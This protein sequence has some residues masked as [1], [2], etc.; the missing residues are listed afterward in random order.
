MSDRYSKMIEELQKAGLTPAKAKN[1]LKA[2]SELGAK[3]PEKLKALLVERRLKTFQGLLL[4]T[5]LDV[6][7]C[8]GGFYIGKASS[9]SNIPGSI[10]FSLVGYFL[11]CYYFLQAV[12]QVTALASISVAAK[13]Y[14][15]DTD[16]LLAAVRE[17]AGPDQPKLFSSAALVVNTLKVIQTL[18]QIGEQLQD[19]GS[20]GSLKGSSLANLS[21][22]LT[23]QRAEEVY[24]FVPE[25]YGL[26]EAEAADIAGVFSRFDTNEDGQLEQ[27]ELR[28]LCAQLGTEISEAEAK[29]AVRILDETKSGYIQFADFVEWFQGRRPRKETKEAAAQAS[30]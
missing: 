12:F 26:T 1:V 13:R 5:V 30:Q 16:V 15:T 25:K 29:E 20:D 27:S 22:Y 14:S 28:N 11:A 9:E 7:A 23:L 8:G 18:E 2:W 10:I 3:D 6:V 24:G 21:A 19:L 4:Q 17:L